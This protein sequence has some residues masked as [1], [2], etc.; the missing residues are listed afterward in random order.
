ML[1]EKID[2]SIPQIA[3][4][5]YS[6]DEK[7]KETIQHI[8]NIL[9]KLESIMGVNSSLMTLVSWLL[10]GFGSKN[11]KERGWPE[12]VDRYLYENFELGRLQAAPY[13]YMAKFAQETRGSGRWGNPTSFYHTPLN[14]SECIAEMLFHGID[15][16]T[17]SVIDPCAGTGTLLLAASNYSINLHAADIAADLCAM[18]EVNGYIYIPWLVRPA[19]W[20]KTAEEIDGKGKNGEF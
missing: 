11:V 16:I 3:F 15:N 2:G 8:E 14:V 20:L 12:K 7:V 10:W 18:C 17:K 13:D 5:L 19:H 9:I 1:T 6:Y 4:H